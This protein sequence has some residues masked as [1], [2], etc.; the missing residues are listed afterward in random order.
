MARTQAGHVYR[1]HAPTV[2][3]ASFP[4]PDTAWHPL[5]VI[6][7]MATLYSQRGSNATIH[8]NSNMKTTYT[9]GFTIFKVATFR[10]VS[11]LLCLTLNT[12]ITTTREY[13][14]ICSF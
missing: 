9:T 8:V 7:Q 4:V 2:I 5:A 12:R 10:F 14:P 13:I 11:G 3:D 6:R 1:T